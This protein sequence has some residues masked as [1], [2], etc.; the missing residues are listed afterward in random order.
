MELW[1]PGARTDTNKLLIYSSQEF[2]VLTG[3]LVYV[4]AFMLFLIDG[5]G[6][7]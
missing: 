7:I 4:P 2:L 6:T 3:A 5:L 1:Q